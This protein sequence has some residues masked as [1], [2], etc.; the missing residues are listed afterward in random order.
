MQVLISQVVNLTRCHFFHFPHPT[1][2]LLLLL[3]PPN[4]TISHSSIIYTPSP[5]PNFFSL[6]LLQQ[7]PQKSP[8]L[9]SCSFT[10]SS[11]F[12]IQQPRSFSESMKQINPFCRLK[13]FMSSYRFQKEKKISTPIYI[14]PDLTWSDSYLPLPHLVLSMFQPCLSHPSHTSLHFM[15]QRY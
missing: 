12:S 7:S 9:N 10:I 1:S 13:T 8:C 6:Q 3:W 15:P 4:P 14:Q 11:L 2:Q 5:S